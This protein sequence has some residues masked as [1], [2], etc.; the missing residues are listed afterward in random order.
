MPH[1]HVSTSYIIIIFVFKLDSW[2]IN[3]FR[4]GVG[5]SVIF[6]FNGNNVSTISGVYQSAVRL[7]SLSLPPTLRCSVL[8]QVSFVLKKHIC[9]SSSSFSNANQLAASFS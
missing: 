3:C 8:I 1:N 5:L 2:E 9:T 4:S 7:L 6:R